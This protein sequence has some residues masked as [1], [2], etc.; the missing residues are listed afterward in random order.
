MSFF[1]ELSVSD[2][3][4]VVTGIQFCLLSPD[5]IKKRSV[6]EIETHDIYNGNEPVTGGVLDNRMGVLDNLHKCPTCGFKNTFCPGHFGHF[7]LAKPV[8]YVQFLDIVKK[9]LRCVCYRCS[10]LLIDWNNTLSRKH[11]LK[12]PREKRFELIYKHCNKTTKRDCPFCKARQPNLVTREIILKIVLE[13]KKDAKAEDE[14]SGAATHLVLYPEDVEKILKRISDEDCESMGFNPGLNRPEWMICTVFPV[15]PPCVRPTVHNDLSQRR[16]DDLT[17]KICDIVKLNNSLKQ[18]IAANKSRKEIEGMSMLLQFHVATFADNQLPGVSPSQHRNGRPIKSVTERLKTKEGRIR[19]NLMGKR[20][21]FSA[22]S[23]ITPD[24]NISIDELGVP[25]KIAMNLTFPEPV[26]KFNIERLQKMVDNGPEIYPGAKFVRKD[27]EGRTVRLNKDMPKGFVQL[28]EGDVVDRHLL[29]GDPVL[30]NRQPSLHRMSMMAHRVHVMPYETFRLNVMVTPCYNADFDG[31]EMNMHVPQSM[32]T[33]VE[34]TELAAVPL[35]ILS[36]RESAPI[37]NVVQDIALGVYKITLPDTTIQNR[38]AQNL[39]SVVSNFDGSYIPQSINVTGTELMSQV[40]PK[41]TYLNDKRVEI[42]NGKIARGQL[43]KSVYSDGSSNNLIQTTFKELGSDATRRLLDDT[44]RI[45]CEWLCSSGFSVGVSDLVVSKEIEV[46]AENIIS[47]TKKNVAKVFQSIHEGTFNNDTIGSNQEYFESTVEAALAKAADDVN[48][49]IP[50]DPLNRL[51]N[52]INSKSKGKDSNLQQMMMLVGQQSVEDEANKKKGRV[53]YGFDGRTLPHFTKFDDSPEARGFVENSYIKGLNPYEFFFHAIAGREGLIDTAVRSVT[54]E[55]PIVVLDNNISKRVLIGEWIDSLISRYPNV[56]YFPKEKNLELLELGDQE[57]FIPTVDNSGNVTWGRMTSVTRHDSSKNLYKFTTKSGREVTVAESKSMIIWRPEKGFVEVDSR[58]IQTGDFAPTIMNIYDTPII[59]K[60]VNVA[61]YL[62]S[63]TLHD[64]NLMNFNLDEEFGTFIGLYLAVG[65]NSDGSIGIT[66]DVPTVQEWVT[67]WFNKYEIV[68]SINVSQN[69]NVTTTTTVGYSQLLAQFLDAFV[70]HD[71]HSKHVPDVV[72][73]TS[74]D[75]VSGILNGYFSG[76]GTIVNGVF[77]SSTLSSQLNEGISFLC[78]RLG[79]FAKT[80]TLY[81][82]KDKCIAEH[83]VNISAQWAKILS[84]RLNIIHSKKANDVKS[85]QYFDNHDDFIVNNDVVLDPI[86]KIEIVNAKENQK[87]YDVTVP[88]TLNFILANGLGVRDTSDTGYIQRKLIKAMEDC[89]VHHDMTIRNING[90]IVQ[91]SYGGDGFDAAKLENQPYNVVSMTLNDIKNNYNLSKNDL[92]GL[93]LCMTPDAYNII[94]K[95]ETFKRFDEYYEQVMEDRKIFIEYCT[96]SNMGRDSKVAEYFVYFPINFRRAILYA[97]KKFKC[98]AGGLSDLDVTYVFN[99]MDTMIKEMKISKAQDQNI[100]LGMLCRAYINPK[101]LVL[102]NRMTKAAFDYMMDKITY[103]FQSS[104]AQPSE[105]VGIISAQSIGEPSTQMSASADTKV[106]IK[107]PSGE[108]YYGPIGA[109]IDNLLVQQSE[110]VV[111]VDHDSVAMLLTSDHYIVGVSDDEKTS[112]KRIKEISRHPSNG[113]MIRIF[114]KSGKSTCATLSHSFLKRSEDRIVPVLGSDLKIGDRVPIAC[115]IPEISNPGKNVRVGTRDI[116]LTEEFGWLIGSYLAI[117]KIYS[118][119]NVIAFRYGALKVQEKLCHIVKEILCVDNAYYGLLETIFCHQDFTTFLITEFSNK[120]IPGWVF[121]SNIKF[122]RGVLGGFFD[123]HT[124]DNMNNASL[125]ISTDNNTIIE[126]IIVLLT[127]VGIFA[128]QSAKP[129]LDMLYNI[130]IDRKYITT[131]KS[132]IGVFNKDNEQ[133]LEDIITSTGLDIMNN[134][135]DKIPEL[136]NIITF[137][138]NTLNLL[139]QSSLFKQY[140]MKDAVDREVLKTYIAIFEDALNDQ[141]SSL[142]EEAM[143]NKVVS[144]ILILRQAAYSDVVWDEI[145]SLELLTDP[146]EFVYDFSV[147]GNDS[148]MVDCGILVHNTLNSIEYNTDV[149]LKINGKMRRMKVGDY[150]ESIVHNAHAKDIEFHPHDTTLAYIKNDTV[151]IMAC[152]KQGRVIWDKVEAVTKHP[153]V[154]D[155]GTNTLLKVSLQSGRQVTATKAKSFLKRVNN[156]IVGV[157][158]SKL[159]VGDFLPVSKVL[160]EQENIIKHIHLFDYLNKSEWI[161]FDN[162]TNKSTELRHNCIYPRDMKGNQHTHVPK[163][164]TLN[165]GLGF[166]MGAYFA[167]GISTIVSANISS[168]QYNVLSQV[169]NFLKTI[170]IDHI[171]TAQSKD[172]ERILTVNSPVIASTLCTFKKRIPMEMVYAPIEFVESFLNSFFSMRCMITKESY[173]YVTLNDSSQGLI[174]DI[175]LM[176]LRLNIPSNYKFENNIYKLSIP[177]GRFFKHIKLINTELYSILEYA[178]KRV[179]DVITDVIPDV[180]TKTY[181]FLDSVKRS[182]L[183]LMTKTACPEDKVIFEHLMVEDIVY[184]KIVNIE[185][186]V[187]KHD[188]VYDFTTSK[189]KNFNIFNGIC[190]ED[191]FHSTGIAAASKSVQ[192]VPRLKELLGA[193]KNMKTPQMTIYLDKIIASDPAKCQ[194]I[195]NEIETTFLRD[196]VSET[197]IYYDP[198]DAGTEIDDDQVFVASWHEFTKSMDCKDTVNSPWLLRLV[199]DKEKMLSKGLTMLDVY[200]GIMSSTVENISC[201]FSDDNAN[202]LVMRI[203][204]EESKGRDILCDLKLMDQQL[205]NDLILKGVSGIRKV[206]KRQ[207]TCSNQLY[208]DD[209]SA[210]TSWKEFILSTDGTNLKEVLGNPMVDKQ[211]TISNDVQEIYR[212]LGIEAARASIMYEIK[213]TLADLIV[214]DRHI[215]LLVDTMTN[216]GSLMSIER[217]GINKGDIGPLAKCSFEE[218]DKN[219]INAGVFAEVDKMVG[220]SANIMLGQIPPVGTGDSKILIDFEKLTKTYDE[221]NNVMNIA[222]TT[223]CKDAIEMSRYDFKP[224]GSYIDCDL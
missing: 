223:A 21:D 185:E 48:K 43:S 18:A 203:R 56:K 54:W 112:W 98:S 30:F 135:I 199:L 217:H 174:E 91:Y 187:S 126:S 64:Q 93:K 183:P 147:P 47:E 179:R 175:Q 7:E 61:S 182:A 198:N 152:T 63:T 100:M 181:G 189:T 119:Q 3:I 213:T 106:I 96:K 153:V 12:L 85:L 35:Q 33:A 81:I 142:M 28:D 134:D 195:L 50:R 178:S 97:D 108:T 9:V 32:Q 52:M 42:I 190:Q 202:K 15:P 90:C 173:T 200:F 19:G 211:Y 24:P 69:M 163:S 220:V 79:V 130:Q 193:S 215:E 177:T 143:Y 208:N 88:S 104:I 205:L 157:D 191:T 139:D 165:K 57:V 31:D 6:C 155:D 99:R 201:I 138:G 159:N 117:G 25:L 95:D 66:K 160:L 89:K 110:N 128:K 76:N 113:G 172:V 58:D 74:S 37:I 158:G 101:I 204:L 109:Y 146:K 1:K 65:H 137:I 136:G 127:F 148:F 67:N 102:K 38:H 210:L 212:V 23:V 77:E 46:N 49:I 4:D 164:L 170:D 72:Y 51:V 184:D 180:N 59:T 70:G 5:E 107:E 68:N 103:A 206:V 221:K 41:G 2:K 86:M 133:I 45:I 71:N 10:N 121:T 149:L 111:E 125:S 115:F 168:F 118:H 87:L 131:F 40:I 218:S 176:L 219:I 114:T 140:I 83:H 122:I 92:E 151:E 166:F 145:I 11:L 36:P 26:N 116:L 78:A 39:L 132:L 222:N 84:K 13:W 207:I 8:F 75:F 224:S 186:V 197:A 16:E 80:F 53:G 209:T 129:G 123:C 154:N 161:C 29:N 196:V 162:D 60:V 169:S 171:I 17:H 34:L 141:K 22:R 156:E 55:T 167:N 150:V 20:V 105:L 124:I 120:Q 216:K 73:S 188:K 194:D 94:S 144:N 44:Q 27:K 82:Q 214:Q 192:G 14:E 62:P